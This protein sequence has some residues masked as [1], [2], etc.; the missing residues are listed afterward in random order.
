MVP[1]VLGWTHVDLINRMGRP[2][3]DSATIHAPLTNGVTSRVVFILM[4]LAGLGTHI[5]DVK[6]EYFHLKNTRK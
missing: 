1:N 5:I 4:S 3:H 6:G 2:I